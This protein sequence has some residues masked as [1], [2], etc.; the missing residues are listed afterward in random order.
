MIEKG[1]ISAFQL[2]ILMYPVV[3]A[4]GDL[5]APATSAKYAGR[6]LWIVPLLS[7]LAGVLVIFIA[8]QLHKLYPNKSLIQYSEQILGKFMGK[9]TIW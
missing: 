6:D 5:W 7:S 2:G 8:Y 9:Q 1:K 4:T 3:V